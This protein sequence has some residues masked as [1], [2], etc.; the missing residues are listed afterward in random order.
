[1]MAGCLSKSGALSLLKAL[2]ESK[3]RSYGKSA[4]SRL[5]IAFKKPLNRLNSPSNGL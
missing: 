3:G 1:M 4:S 2:K 5:Q